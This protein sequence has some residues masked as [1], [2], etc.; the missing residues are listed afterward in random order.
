MSAVKTGDL[1]IHGWTIFAHPFFVAQ[2][3]TLVQQVEVL[4]AL[5][6]EHKHWFRAKFFQQFRL[7]FRYHAASRVILYAWVNDDTKR[8]YDSSSDTYLVFRKMLVSSHPPDNWDQLLAEC[9]LI[10]TIV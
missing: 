3:E 2:I 6:D 5:G 1:L 8:S 9:V 4:G 7:F 10:E